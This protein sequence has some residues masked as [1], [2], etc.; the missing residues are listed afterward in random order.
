MSDIYEKLRERLREARKNLPRVS[1]EEA[2][3]QMARSLRGETK[4]QEQPI[5]LPQFKQR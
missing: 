1:A 5:E 3:A 2:Y 4:S